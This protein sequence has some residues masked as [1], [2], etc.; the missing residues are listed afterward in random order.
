M[1]EFPAGL[2]SKLP[3]T[4]TSIFAIMSQ[5]AV[6]HNAI[7]L[8]QGFPDF[9][10]SA[11]LIGLINHYMKK[12]YNQYAPMPGVPLL[13]ERI[14]EKV[15]HSYGIQYDPDKEINITAGATQGIYT[16]IAAMIREEDEVIIFEPAYDSYAP[17]VK[18]CGGVV[19]YAH[20]H[21]PKYHIDWSEV[22]SLVTHRT[23]LIIINSPHNP[24][25]S[26]LRKE[27]LATLERLTRK[28]DICVLSDEVYEHL[29]FDGEP[30]ESVCKYPGLAERSFITA[31]FG[32]TFHATGWK[33]GYVLAP[34]ALMAEYR[35]A[36][37]FVVFACNTPVQHA[38]ADY[39][40]DPGNYNSLSSF[41]Q[42][43]RDYFAHAI[44]NS[45]FEIVPCHGT[46]FQLLDY[47]RISDEKEMDFAS[48]LIKEYGIATIPVSPFYHNGSENKVVRVC[49]AKK[50][51]TLDQAAEILC[52]I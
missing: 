25:G 8:S 15:F 26:I 23:R 38:I 34:E 50:E 3:N 24:T 37:Q 52:K 32:K 22:A 45:R 40:E 44:S 36:H 31:S 29:I 41:Y 33:M 4:G 9:D 46:Y 42:Q 11:E 20:L 10:V 2:K 30:H 35:K 48:R 43:K 27:D 19:K 47:Q 16:I 5:M 51:E 18:L 49:F 14:S 6:E 28:S 21:P 7:N 1:I 39:L 17:A 13:R 12:G